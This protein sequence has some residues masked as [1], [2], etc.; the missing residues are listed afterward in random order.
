MIAKD[1]A[2]RIGA[3]TGLVL[4]WALMRF[5]GYSGVMPAAIF[6]ASFC[7]VGAIA[8]EQWHGRKRL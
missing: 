2:R 5:L 7:V 6:G 4:G 1:T 8:G 3:V